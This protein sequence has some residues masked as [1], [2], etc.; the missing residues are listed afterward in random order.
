MKETT[1]ATILMGLATT[2]ILIFIIMVSFFISYGKAFKLKNVIINE[3]EQAEGMSASELS[4]YVGA[5]GLY[6]GKEIGACFE[7]IYFE[8]NITGYVIRVKVSFGMD[9]TILGENLNVNIPIIGETRI[10][11]KGTH[12]GDPPSVS[13]LQSSLQMVRCNGDHYTD[14]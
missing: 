12:L 9:R 14:L 7:P 8:S 6:V 1:G 10:I 11:Q 3:I 5:S 4:H 13:H 2:I